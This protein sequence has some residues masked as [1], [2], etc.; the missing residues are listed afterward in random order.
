MYMDFEKGCQFLARNGCDFADEPGQEVQLLDSDKLCA[1]PFW[2]MIGTV[3]TKAYRGSSYPTGIVSFPIGNQTMSTLANPANDTTVYP[4][5]FEGMLIG[6]PA[7]AELM[8]YAPEDTSNGAC[9]IDSGWLWTHALSGCQGDTLKFD[10]PFVIPPRTYAERGMTFVLYFPSDSCSNVGNG[11]RIY[12]NGQVMANSTTPLY[13]SGD[14]MYSTQG[15]MIMDTTPPVIT[16]FNALPVDSTHLAITITGV[17]DTTAVTVGFVVYTING[18]PKQL[19]PL[20]FANNLAVGDTTIFKDT[21]VSA[22][23]YPVINIKGFVQNQVGLTDSSIVEILPLKAQ[24]ESVNIQAEDSLR[25]NYLLIDHSS[26][27]LTLDVQAV[28]AP[29]ELDLVTE[30]GRSAKLTSET[31]SPNG[32]QKFVQSFSNFANGAYFLVIHSGSNSIIE[33]IVL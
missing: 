14:Y 4:A 18:G 21:L 1:H 11:K 9:V 22:V 32:E 6:A 8:I 3:D 19:M 31:S 2:N 28:G 16:N 20:R 12:L 25:V 30:D 24:P 10:F 17:D 15:T 29:I 27:T 23:S 7:N 26:K 33:N 5:K 13:D